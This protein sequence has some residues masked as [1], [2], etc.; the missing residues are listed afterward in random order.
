MDPAYWPG[1][2][3]GRLHRLTTMKADAATP[4]RYGT[5]GVVSALCLAGMAT[6]TFANVLS[7]YLFH[8]SFA[9][10]EEVTIHLFVIMVVAASGLAFERGAHLGMDALTRRCSL[11]I[12]RITGQAA[13][14]LAGLL[15][16]VLDASLVVAIYHE[17]TLFQARSPALG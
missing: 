11:R 3:P 2:L 4:H 12:Q 17:I 13:A 8:V 9:F 5:A 1:G 16:L 7:R 14:I 10:T 6:I 15:F